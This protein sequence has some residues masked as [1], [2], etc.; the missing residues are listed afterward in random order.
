MSSTTDPHNQSSAEIERQVEGTRAGLA[1]SLDVLRD[2]VSPDHLMDQA[3]QYVRN[4][5]G[6]DFTRNLTVAVRENPLPVLLIGAGIGWMLMSGQKSA[7][8]VGTSSTVVR[9][10]PGSAPAATV[11]GASPTSRSATVS[12]MAGSTLSG[13]GSSAGSAASSARDWVS[14]T[15]TTAQQATSDA[16][17]R[18]GKLAG[19]AYAAASSAAGSAAGQVAEGA[20]TVGG[21]IA[22][23]A[24]GAQEQ[25][26]RA[27]SS[28]GST[29]GAS[30][31]G[32]QKILHDQPLALAA[33]GIAV[34]AAVGALIPVTQAENRLLGSTSDA[35]QEKVK[36]AA[37]D[38]LAQ[39]KQAAGEH[40]DTVKSAVA[41]TIDHAQG[42]IQEGGLSSQTLG[43]TLGTA[44]HE[45]RQVVQDTVHQAAG[46]VHDAV[47]N[48]HPT[49]EAPKSP[50]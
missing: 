26:T 43:D 41:N 3:V 14:Q 31:Q 7:D 38:G 21:H 10:I 42:H 4:A 30:S 11:P 23:L 13:L 36:S 37:H 28:V 25:V 16:A 46:Q 33:L 24:H 47:G 39:V 44:A 2:R 19:D 34:G 5:G 27:G 29:V 1:H 49:D 35:L 22:D 45:L 20:S 17:G 40:L 6:D 15:T 50:A 8:R 32:L 9:R 12:E 18:A 48:G